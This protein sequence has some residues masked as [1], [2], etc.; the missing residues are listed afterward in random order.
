MP[1][2]MPTRAPDGAQADRLAELHAQCRADYEQAAANRAAAAGA[3][4][5]QLAL[6][7][8]HAAEGGGRR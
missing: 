1:E 8:A 2:S 3:A 5:D 6:A 4:R 7:R